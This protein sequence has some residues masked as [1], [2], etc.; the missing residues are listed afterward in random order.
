MARPYKIKRHKRICRRSAGSI[1]ARAAAIIAAVAVLFG[2]GLGIIWSCQ[3]LDF[4]KSRMDP[5]S[6]RRWSPAFLS[7]LHSRSNREAAPT[8]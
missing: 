7:L 5:P 2:L 1:L 8:G 3:R 4:T 6:N